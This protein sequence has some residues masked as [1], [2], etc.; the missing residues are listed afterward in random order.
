MM[1]LGKN[2]FKTAIRARKL[3]IGLWC[4]LCSSTATELVSDSGYDWMLLD[5][6]HAPNEVP[7]I[8]DQLRSMSSGTAAP[9]VR[10]AWNDPVLIKRFLAFCAECG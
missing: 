9:I 4:S 1:D 8:L 5:T 2:S 6:E 7:G 3:Q 10:P